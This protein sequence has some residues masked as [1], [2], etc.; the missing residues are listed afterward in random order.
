MEGGPLLW[1]FL[2]PPCETHTQ[3]RFLSKCWWER[4]PPTHTHTHEALGVLKDSGPALGMTSNI[5]I[6]PGISNGQWQRCL[7]YTTPGS[8]YDLRRHLASST[9]FTRALMASS[10]L[11]RKLCC[12]A[13]GWLS[14]DTVVM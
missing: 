4:H 5:L 10:G 6:V 11:F 2:L 13:E 8:G 9:D 3:D 7:I 1:R 14:W 12:G